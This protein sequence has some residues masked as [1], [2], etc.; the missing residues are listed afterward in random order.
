MIRFDF[1]VRDDDDNTRAEELY[2][3]LKAHATRKVEEYGD[4]AAEATI[5]FY[6]G[7][8][9]IGRIE[10][11]ALGLYESAEVADDIDVEL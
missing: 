4:K 1:D 8:D 10:K 9:V 11:G 6:D 7:D 3:Q 5:T 2:Y